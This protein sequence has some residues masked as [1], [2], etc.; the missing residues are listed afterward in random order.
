MKTLEESLH[1][2]SVL[3]G[4]AHKTVCVEESGAKYT[5]FFSL[6]SANPLLILSD[7]AFVCPDLTRLNKAGRLFKR[8]SAS[9]CTRS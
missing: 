7:P 4:C 6:A 2:M 8:S 1:V 3:F 5:M 9:L